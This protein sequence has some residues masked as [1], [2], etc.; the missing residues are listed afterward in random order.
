VHSSREWAEFCGRVLQQPELA[1][2]PRFQTNVTRVQHREAL[3][4]AIET[5]LALLPSAEVL[6]RLETAHIANARVNSMH[7][8]LEHPQLAARDCWR[9]I[10][11]P[12]G[13]I[14]ALLPPVRMEHVEP[15]MGAVPALGQHTRAILE[16]LDFDRDTIARWAET[17]VIS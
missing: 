9:E 14:R 16:E 15:V 3:T 7:E 6:R 2:D 12:A 17:G 5:V 4:A 11:S 8:Y 10:D 1:Q 13:P